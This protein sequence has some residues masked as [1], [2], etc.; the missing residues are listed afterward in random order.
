MLP[1]THTGDTLPT[2]RPTGHAIP[3]TGKKGRNIM[4]LNNERKADAV[5][6][7]ITAE[8]LMQSARAAAYC[9]VRRA[10]LSTPRTLR[11]ATGQ[12]AGFDGSTTG[13]A[14]IIRRLYQG[15]RGGLHAAAGH[16]EQAAAAMDNAATPAEQAAALVDLTAALDAYTATLSNDADD[17]IQT[18]ALALWQ[19]IVDN[20]GQTAP[21]GAFLDACRAVDRQIYAEQS[22]TG[23]RVRT[24]TD[25]AGNV[26]R[27]DEYRYTRLP[28]LYIDHLS[29]DANGEI[30]ADI[31]DVSDALSR[32][33][34]G[35]GARD[36]IQT[37]LLPLSKPEKQALLWHAAGLTYDTIARR[38]NTTVPAVKM[39]VK[40]AREKAA[41]A[42]AKVNG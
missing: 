29:T 24:T 7:P 40:R 12:V 18:A 15:F 6:P 27:S 10:Y 5:R 22:N 13:G 4:K 31:V 42:L 39:R 20:D 32:Y 23:T 21:D 11:D 28:H 35:Q 17:L 33:M 36:D 30:T 34:R 26:L 9:T 19:T 1:Y 3:T 25:A 41:A 2:H 8:T 38:L 16:A 37:A 14:D